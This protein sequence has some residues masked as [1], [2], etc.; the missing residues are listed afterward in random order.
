MDTSI[1]TS[2]IARMRINCLGQYICTYRF[3]VYYGNWRTY[4]GKGGV[5]RS[6][7]NTDAVVVNSASQYY[8]QREDMCELVVYSTGKGR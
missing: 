1:L 3:N 2:V 8:I 4:G 5:G 7:D 6:H